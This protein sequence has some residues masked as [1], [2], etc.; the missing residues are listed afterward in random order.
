MGD[1]WVNSGQITRLTCIAEAL[2]AV[3]PIGGR[4][5]DALASPS[6]SV[7]GSVVPQL[8]AAFSPMTAPVALVLDDVY[9]G[10]GWRKAHLTSFG[11]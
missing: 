3:E 9:A 2:D 1:V 6:S 7:L 10:P 4:V 11:R 8:G 5:L